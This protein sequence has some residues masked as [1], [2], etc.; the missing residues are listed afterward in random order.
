MKAAVLGAG[1]MGS[2]ITF[3]L[4]D[5][6]WEVR[7]WGTWLDDEIIDKCRHGSHPKLKKKLPEN[8]RLYGAMELE[9]AIE[10]ADIVFIA[11]TSE[12]F[13]PVFD[14]YLSTV[15][16]TGL[17]LHAHTRNTNSGRQAI[18]ALTKGFVRYKGRVYCI[19][20]AAEKMHSDKFNAS[21]GTGVSRE[22]DVSKGL[23]WISIGGPVKAVEL[24]ERVPTAT[25]YATCR[26][27][28]SRNHYRNYNRLL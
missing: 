5:A 16:E 14:R 17:A 21:E 20:E 19:S 15:G 25:V 4:C 6:G 9:S 3:P 24:S 22:N 2:A 23:S 13:V 18:C 1:Y 10:G 12:G 26:S 28:S 8:I 27:Q 11:V 7:L